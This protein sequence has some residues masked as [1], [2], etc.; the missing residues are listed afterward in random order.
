MIV[1]RYYL[2]LVISSEDTQQ[3]DQMSG[4][5]EAAMFRPSDEHL[6]PIGD[7]PSW[8]ESVVITWWDE[9]AGIGGFH[10]IGH[11][12]HADDGQGIATCWTGIHSRSGERFCEYYRSPLLPQDRQ[13][14]HTFGAG[15]A[16]Q[17]RFE[18]D[19]AVWTVREEGCELDLVAED[20]TPRFDLFRQGGT[21][22]DDFAPGHLEA[23]GRVS[24][25]VHLGDHRASIAGLC[26]RDHS[27]G[28]RD[29]SS[30]LSHRWVAGTCGP[31]LTFNATSWHG[32]DGS[33]RSFGVLVRNGEVIYAE[34]VEIV[35]WME[36][37]AMTHR[38]GAITL[39]LS[40]SEDIVIQMHAVDGL[41][42]LHNGVACVDELCEFEFKGH[43]GFCDL[44]IS[45]NPRGGT[46]PVSALVN[47]TLEKGF[48][49]KSATP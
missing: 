5:S 1:L 10:R 6:H 33:L 9:K 13:Y 15:D 29:W 47:A 40:D 8:Q 35:V 18:D 42:T 21:V 11:E 25:E 28:R 31:E 7:D 32:V 17:A 26:Y 38:G 4:I 36:I 19:K 23:A 22:T 30:L 2:T 24:G 27:W 49:L 41:V 44:E 39:K 16:Y 48:S 12:P 34:S 43:K 37:D 45:T 3:S 14:P 46:G 20:Y